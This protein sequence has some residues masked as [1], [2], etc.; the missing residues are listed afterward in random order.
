MSVSTEPLPGFIP[1][2]PFT[3]II[4]RYL[5]VRFK[6]GMHFINPPKTL[7]TR[8]QILRP[9]GDVPRH[10]EQAVQTALPTPRAPEPARLPVP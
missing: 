7:K 8:R 4:T 6:K 1:S 9:R 10:S 3:G 2:T 5:G